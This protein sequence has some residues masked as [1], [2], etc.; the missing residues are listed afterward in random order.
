MNPN[1]LTNIVYSKVFIEIYSYVFETLKFGI[2]D[3]IKM[4]LKKKA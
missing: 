2:T 4:I 1:K 3:D